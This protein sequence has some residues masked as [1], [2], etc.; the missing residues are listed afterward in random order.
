VIFVKISVVEA[1]LILPTPKKFY[2]IFYVVHC[3]SNFDKFFKALYKK[4]LHPM[5]VSFIQNNG[6]LFKR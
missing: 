5:F 3:W 6:T 1:T 4:K 2:P